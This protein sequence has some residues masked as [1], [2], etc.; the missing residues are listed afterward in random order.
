MDGL[1]YPK[2]EKP[3]RFIDLAMGFGVKYPIA[4]PRG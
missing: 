4:K 2:I 1:I 3:F